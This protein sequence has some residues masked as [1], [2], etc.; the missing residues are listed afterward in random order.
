MSFMTAQQICDLARQIA[1][2]PG[3]TQQSGFYLNMALEDLAQNYDFEAIKGTFSFSFSSGSNGPYPLPADWYRGIDRDIY[4]T[5]SGVH[6]PMV[7]VEQE[8][9]DNLVTTAGLNGFPIYYTVSTSVSP[10]TMS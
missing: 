6:Y 9:F 1:K 3:Y 8:E 2:C 4:Y 7:N 5:I 10:P